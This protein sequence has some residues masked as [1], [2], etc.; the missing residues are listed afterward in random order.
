MKKPWSS[1]NF[2]FSCLQFLRSSLSSL[3]RCG[4][5]R[6]WRYRDTC[7]LMT[8]LL[9]PEPKPCFLKRAIYLL[10]WWNF[11]HPT[12]CTLVGVWLRAWLPSLAVLLWLWIQFPGSW[13]LI[14]IKKLVVLFQWP[15]EACP[16]GLFFLFALKTSWQYWFKSQHFYLFGIFAYSF[17]A[18]LSHLFQPGDSCS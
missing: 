9:V 13:Q 18:F 5:P 1:G 14:W 11:R 17:L 6:W 3:L 12:P 8:Y 16:L 7:P 10:K 4:C 2:Q 15:S